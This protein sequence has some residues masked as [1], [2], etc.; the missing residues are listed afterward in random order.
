[1]ERKIDEDYIKYLITEYK[2]VKSIKLLKVI[3]SEEIIKYINTTVSGKTI[4]NIILEDGPINVHSGPTT[5]CINSHFE[6]YSDFIIKLLNSGFYVYKH[7]NKSLLDSIFEYKCCGYHHYIPL[8]KLLLKQNINYDYNSAIKNIS[9]S[10]EI[11]GD[12]DWTL[13]HCNED[14]DNILN[15]IH[16]D[17]LRKIG[18]E[19][20]I[21]SP[22]ELCIEI[23][24][25]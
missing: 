16:A 9:K 6:K 7:E 21:E 15:I 3:N 8:V 13:S 10:L 5:G 23:T 20:G 12:E 14:D 4:I 25:Y 11:S 24:S 2:T 17:C 22:L 19:Y 1:M 18:L